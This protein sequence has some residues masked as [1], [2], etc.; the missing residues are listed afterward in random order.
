M[1]FKIN[2]LSIVCSTACSGLEQVKHQSVA[3]LAFS[4]GKPPV[5]DWGIP[6]TKD[7]N[8]KA[9]HCYFVMCLDDIHNGLP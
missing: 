8:S 7:Q 5:T 9:D 3:L 4:V 2:D 6:I 1:V